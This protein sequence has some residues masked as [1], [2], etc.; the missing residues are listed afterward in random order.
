[1]SKLIHFGTIYGLIDMLSYY[2]ANDLDPSSATFINIG[3]I[4]NYDLCVEEIDRNH[5]IHKQV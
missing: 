1:M 4:Q 2:I 3:P 5:Y